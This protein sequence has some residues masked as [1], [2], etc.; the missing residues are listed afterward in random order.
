[1]LHRLFPLRCENAC[2]CGVGEVML[3]CE[4]TCAG[5]ARGAHI[6]RDV[7]GH[8][9]VWRVAC[10]RSHRAARTCAVA[11][12]GPTHE[13]RA[14]RGKEIQDAM[15][16][17]PLDRGVQVGLGQ[18][19]RSAHAAARCGCATGQWAMVTM[20]T[21]T[22]RTVEEGEGERG[23]RRVLPSVKSKM[24][25]RVAATCNSHLV[26]WCVARPRCLG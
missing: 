18:L 6:A 9:L 4:R 20:S 26:S 14:E 17:S 23:A 25:C 8:V 10:G 15:T 21:T 12:G 19:H 7:R 13:L 16:C 22:V 24:S 3:R 5:V 2:W 1:V 11:W